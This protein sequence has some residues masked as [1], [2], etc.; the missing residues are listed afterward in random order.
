MVINF[1]TWG[2][3]NYL[4]LDCGTRKNPKLLMKKMHVSF[5]LSCKKNTGLRRSQS[6]LLGVGCFPLL[7]DPCFPLLPACL[8]FLI[9]G[10]VK[11]KVHFQILHILLTFC[12]ERRFINP[13]LALTKFNEFYL[14]RIYFLICHHFSTHFRMTTLLKLHLPLFGLARSWQG[15]SCK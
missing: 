2:L 14:H 1:C 10:R 6:V 5:L 3:E 7:I 15:P 12:G 4:F 13:G 9:E 11:K 8:F